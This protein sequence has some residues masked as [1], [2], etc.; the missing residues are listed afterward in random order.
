MNISAPNASKVILTTHFSPLACGF[1]MHRQYF[2]IEVINMSIIAIKSDFLM[3]HFFGDTLYVNI[4]NI[5]RMFL[6]KCLNKHFYILFPWSEKFI[7]QNLE[8]FCILIFFSKRT[9]YWP[10]A[11]KMSNI[12]NMLKY[13]FIMPLLKIW[14]F[15]VTDNNLHY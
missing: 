5:Y 8:R 2:W 3:H 14:N 4:L 12:I 1:K 13:S 7:R 9:V 11:E 15:V 10:T 6:K